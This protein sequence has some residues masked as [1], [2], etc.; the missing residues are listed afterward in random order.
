MPSPSSGCRKSARS[1]RVPDGPGR[2][3]WMPIHIQY[4]HEWALPRG[5]GGHRA[6]QGPRRQRLRNHARWDGG[7]PQ[8]PP[9][10]EGG[11]ADL[12]VDLRQRRGIARRE[13]LGVKVSIRCNVNRQNR[14]GVLPLLERIASEG[15]QSKATFYV[16][17]IHDWGNTAGMRS[18]P[19]EEYAGLGGEPDGGDGQ[20][21]IQA[22]SAAPPWPITCM[23]FKPEA[24]LVD[25]SGNL[26]NCTEVSLVPAYN[27]SDSQG[28]SASDQRRFRVRAGQR[29]PDRS[30]ERGRLPRWTP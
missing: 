12:R 18:A 10:Y 26:F 23:V 9:P 4:D 20:A 30:L 15:L 2:P 17:P 13:D 19:A 1:P 21:G 11:I 22:R 6:R 27:R 7:I 5:R 14:E 28:D 8:P 24:E 25:P 16:A 29:L 3:A